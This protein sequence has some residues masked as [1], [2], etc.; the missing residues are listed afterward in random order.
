MKSTIEYIKKRAKQIT[1]VPVWIFPVSG[2]GVL[3]APTITAALLVIVPFLR[4]IKNGS[5]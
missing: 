1:E 2:L 5:E 4:P 3:L